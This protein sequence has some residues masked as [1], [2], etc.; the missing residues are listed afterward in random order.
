MPEP[1]LEAIEAR[2]AAATKES[3]RDLGG[4]L[5]TVSNRN[6]QQ[7]QHVINDI[8]ARF[9]IVDAALIDS[10]SGRADLLEA[11]NPKEKP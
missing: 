11:L 3:V 10:A 9:E 7:D 1:D 4:E 6:Q 5:L 2:A 8:A